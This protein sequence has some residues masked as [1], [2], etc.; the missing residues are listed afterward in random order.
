KDYPEPNEWDQE[1]V[2]SLRA[3]HAWV[4]ENRQPRRVRLSGSRRLS[5][6][7]ALGAVLSAVAGY[8]LE[9]EYRGQIWATDAHPDAATGAYLLQESLTGANGDRLTVAISLLRD[10]SAG[11]AAYSAAAGLKSNP[12][13]HLRGD[14]AVE[15][16]QQANVL[17]RTVKDAITGALG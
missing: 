10:V 11:V 1:V 7:F 15:S 4:V 6:A 2:S 14:V 8:T 12:V 3:F 16:P 13:L 5:A 9:M 17:A